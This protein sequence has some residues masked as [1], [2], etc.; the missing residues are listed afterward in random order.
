MWCTLQGKYMDIEFDYKGDPVGGIIS[1]CELIG[2]FT[3]RREHRLTDCIFSPSLV[4]S[5]TK[6]LL[7][8]VSAVSTS[9][10]LRLFPP[11]MSTPFPLSSPPSLPFLFPPFVPPS[12]SI[13]HE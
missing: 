12:L 13:S 9:R 10:S 5:L 7:E 4:L 1:N 11:F 3:L 6:D 8:K 2:W